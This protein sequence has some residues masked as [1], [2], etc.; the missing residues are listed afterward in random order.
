MSLVNASSFRR[1]SRDDNGASGC[2][3]HC[4]RGMKRVVMLL[5]MSASALGERIAEAGDRDLWGH[6]WEP[7]VLT[8]A[9]GF[10]LA[11]KEAL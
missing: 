6:L 1:I 8:E 10:E 4:A 11:A 7:G 2:G 9:Q 3:G 5:C